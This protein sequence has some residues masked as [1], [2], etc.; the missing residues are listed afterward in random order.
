MKWTTPNFEIFWSGTWPY[1]CKLGL[2]VFCFEMDVEETFDVFVKVKKWLEDNLFSASPY[3]KCTGF[4]LIQRETYI[5]KCG[6]LL[7]LSQFKKR[8]QKRI[9]KLLQKKKIHFILEELYNKLKPVGSQPAR[10]YGFIKA[11]KKNNPLQP[12]V[13]KPG[14]T[15]HAL[16][17]ELGNYLRELHEANIYTMLRRFKKPWRTWPLMMMRTSWVKMSLALS[18][19]CPWQT[20]YP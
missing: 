17:M 5:F 7:A 15:Y 1:S 10:F 11:H 2:S 18:I 13:A 4:C 3:D 19:T 12:I 16:A 20:R 6:N 14:S 8:L 9:V